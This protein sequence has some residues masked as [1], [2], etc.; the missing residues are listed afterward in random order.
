MCHPAAFISVNATAV[1]L[2]ILAKKTAMYGVSVFFNRLGVR[3]FANCEAVI[4]HG[5]GV[6]VAICDEN[7]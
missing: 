4:R 6:L 3:F 2:L 1:P 7:C 5:A